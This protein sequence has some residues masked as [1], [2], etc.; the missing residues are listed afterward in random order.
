MNLIDFLAAL[1]PHKA[2]LHLTHNQH[3]A[4]YMTV[5][6]D[7]EG[8]VGGGGDWVSEEQRLLAYATNEKWELQWYPETPVGC[9]IFRAATLEALMAHVSAL[10]GDHAG[11]D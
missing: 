11:S 8:P 10:A 2:S 3:L 5:E 4:Y 9:H 7:E 6:E 1:P